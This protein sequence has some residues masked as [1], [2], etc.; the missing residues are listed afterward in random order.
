[1]HAYY[2]YWIMQLVTIL[3]A[4]NKYFGYSVGAFPQA[5]TGTVMKYK[6]LY[7]TCQYMNIR[8]MQNL[9]IQRYIEYKSGAIQLHSKVMLVQ[10][11]PENWK[12]ETDTK[13]MATLW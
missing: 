6:I 10:H 2:N 5:N 9:V 7:N 11:C 8:T 4:V 13:Y 1:M 12:F 3:N